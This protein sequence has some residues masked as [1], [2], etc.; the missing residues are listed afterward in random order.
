MKKS[1]DIYPHETVISHIRRLL[2]G[3][4]T[5]KTLCETPAQFAVRVK[6]VEDYMNSP[7]FAASPGGAGL[8]GLAKELRP[9]CEELVRRQGERIPK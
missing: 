7:A 2:Y 4:F 9:R 8:L 5:C 1:G 6:K 3:E